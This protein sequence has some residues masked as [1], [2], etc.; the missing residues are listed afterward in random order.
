ME[1]RSAR[2]SETL[3]R[4]QRRR[5]EAAL[6][7]LR[8]SQLDQ[9]WVH[10][11]RALLTEESAAEFSD[12]RRERVWTL[13]EQRAFVTQRAELAFALELAEG[14]RFVAKLALEPYALPFGR[15]APAA[16]VSGL[17]SDGDEE[18][19]EHRARAL[20][21]ASQS[22]TSR[23]LE[24]RARA[25]AVYD[26]QLESLPDAEPDPLKDLGLPPGLAEAF[27]RALGAPQ[28]SAAQPAKPATTTPSGIQ[29][30]ETAA[31]PSVADRASE[32][33]ASTDDATREMTRWLVRPAAQSGTIPWYL[34]LRA[35]R[36]PELDG[37]AK[38][39]RRLARV[40]NGLRGL[41]FERDLNARVRGEVAEVSLEPRPR[42]IAISVPSDIRVAQSKLSFGVMSD[43]YAAHGVG[44]G[45]ALALTSPAL[46][47]LLRRP[48]GA[49]IADLLGMTFMQLRADPEYLRRENLEPLWV[50]KLGRH[51]GILVLLEV[52]LQAALSLVAS[53]PLGHKEWSQQ[54]TAA[55]ERALGVEVP[56]GL[57]TL[58][59]WATPPGSG[60]FEASAAGLAA[61]IALRE[62]F[63]ADWYRNPRVSEV[64]R[65]AATRGPALELSVVLD[66]LGVSASVASRRAIEL[67]A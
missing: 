65:G 5:A 8:R 36:A 16:L 37:L 4:V 44:H 67:L 27:G 42:V 2:L 59:A 29:L 38:P 22:L 31:P 56:P 54:L 11:A 43:V 30:P 55:V 66:E 20:A 45:L 7:W 41:G 61:H 6:S 18:G 21:D 50:E 40:A 17:S 62:R 53:Q 60:A 24:L 19:R 14:A 25:L 33:L 13:P 48:T 34:L 57:V 46:P 51:A 49:G 3:E 9:D 1:S 64:L 52:R 26:E 32:F 47:D 15:E 35:L 10:S 28:P 39:A 63:D 23:L 58:A 12:A